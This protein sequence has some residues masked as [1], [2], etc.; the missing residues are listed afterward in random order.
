MQSE[1]AHGR[2]LIPQADSAMGSAKY[3]L[4]LL[5]FGVS[6]HHAGAPPGWFAQVNPGAGI[7]VPLGSC[8]SYF[9][10]HATAVYIARNSV[11]GH[12]ATIGGGMRLEIVTIGKLA[13]SLDGE[14]FFAMY[15]YPRRNKTYYLPGVAPVGEL[16]YQLDKD[17]SL[18]IAV[19][20]MPVGQGKS[21]KLYYATLSVAL[22][23]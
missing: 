1:H 20:Y 19:I 8:L 6:E 11:R 13:A 5:V 17:T 7:Q 16:A 9:E 18:G 15:Q 10:C 3:R 22:D 4:T 21:I 14:A 23:R 2:E 12:A